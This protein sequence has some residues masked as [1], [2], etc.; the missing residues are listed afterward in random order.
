MIS[1]KGL[2]SLDAWLRGSL[3]IFTTSLGFAKC[4][5][6]PLFILQ[7]IFIAW[8]SFCILEIVL[9]PK[10]KKEKHFCSPRKK[11]NTF[12]QPILKLEN[13]FAIILKLG[14]HFTTIW[15]FGNHLAT[16]WEFHS[17]FRSCKMVYC[18]AKFRS[19]CFFLVFELLLIPSFLLSPL[20][21]FLLI[22]IIP[23]TYV[24]SKQIKIKALKS[25][26]KQVINKTK[27]YGLASL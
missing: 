18:V 14:D 9:Q 7:V 12:W 15:K 22:L 17:P 6:K 19:Q 1:V 27:R 21:T 10:G 11:I 25:K 4:F 23:K 20:L 8:R 13:H 26:L 3:R 24:T 16:K 5:R 2:S